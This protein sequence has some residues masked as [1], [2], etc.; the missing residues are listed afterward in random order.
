MTTEVQAGLLFGVGPVLP[1]KDVRAAVAYF[2]QVLGFTDGD[3][4]GDPPSHGSVSRD[5]VGIQFTQA[6]DDFAPEAYPG[7]TYIFTEDVD[8]LCAE[9]R[10]KG[11]EITREPESH[12]HGMREFEI[13]EANGYRLR[14][15][16]YLPR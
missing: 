5:R 2:Q 7:W 9:Y 14:F 1:V 11:V 4:W 16:Q 3:V 13:R 15:G 10:D 8:T 12:D 6:P